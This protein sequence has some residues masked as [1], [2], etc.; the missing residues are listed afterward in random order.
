MRCAPDP[1]L[2]DKTTELEVLKAAARQR[3][4][5]GQAGLDLGMDGAAGPRP[6]TSTTPSTAS[7]ALRSALSHGNQASRIGPPLE[8]IVQR[9]A[10]QLAVVSIPLGMH[11]RAL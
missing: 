2:A 4:G 3:L 7:T 5:A 1:E 11:Q 9:Y 10:S 6:T 8:R